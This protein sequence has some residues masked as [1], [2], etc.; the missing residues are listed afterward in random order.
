M[1]ERNEPWTEGTPCWVDVATSD[2]DASRAFYGDLFGWQSDE[3]S[4]EFGGYTM[5]F[6]KGRPVAGFAPAREGAPIAWHTY[7][8]TADADAT[9]AKV[10]ANGGELLFPLM[11][12]ATAGRMGV[13]ADGAGGTVSFWQAG[14]HVGFGLANEPGTDVWN[15]CMTADYEAAKKFYA[16]VFGVSLNEMGDGSL[17]YS[18]MNIDGREVGGIGAVDHGATPGWRTYFAVADTDDTVAQVQR[19]GGAVLKEAS[20]TPFGRMATLADPQGAVFLVMG[21]S[22][23]P[24]S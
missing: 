7:L 9:A 6:L 14:D 1:V 4:P 24:S 19:L 13:A 15:E 17:R 3:G 11:D 20:D 12:V 22:G 10:V 5:G 2:I 16:A 18:S 23:E 8:A 21:Y